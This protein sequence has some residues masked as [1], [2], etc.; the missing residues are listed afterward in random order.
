MVYHHKPLSRHGSMDGSVGWLVHHFSLDWN[1]STPSTWITITFCADSHGHQ[2]INRYDFPDFLC[3]ATMKSEYLWFRVKRSQRFLDGFLWN[4][5]HIFISLSGLI[6]TTFGIL[7][8]FQ[9]QAKI[10]V[11][12]NVL[13]DLWPAKVILWVQCWLVNVSM[14][15][16]LRWWTLCY[17]CYT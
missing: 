14:L 5:I 10:L 16:T 17:T 11:C 8:C 6:K 9:H 2:R 4:L 7:S 12:T 13:F 3:S 15:N 1:I